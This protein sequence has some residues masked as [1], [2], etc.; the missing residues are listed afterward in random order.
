M[1][2][3][4]VIAKYQNSRLFRMKALCVL[5]AFVGLSVAIPS[6]FV[7]PPLENGGKNWAL[8]V[9][10]S[11]GWGNY[12]HQA[13]VC[14][15]YQILKSH[16]IPDEQIIVMM[17]D[18][19][20]NNKM[21][22]TPGKIINRP[23]GDDVYHGVLKDYT[24]LK[25]VAPDVFLKVLQG[26][27]EELA[28]IGSGKENLNS[29]TIEKQFKIVKRETNTSTVCQ[30]G[31]MKIDSMTVSEFQGSSQSNQIVYPIPDPNV[32]AVPSEDVD[33]H[34][35]MNLFKLA[36]TAEDRKYYSE[37]IAQ[38]SM[39]RGKVAPLIQKI[40]SIATNSN[41]RQ[42]ER[43]MK[44][45]M[46]LFRHECYKAAVEHLA[47]TCPQLEL[48]QQFGYAFKHLY[49]F[50][51]LCEE[52][53]PTET[54]LEAITKGCSLV[55]CA[56][57]RWLSNT[58]FGNPANW[59]A[60]RAPCGNDVA[61]IHDESAA[62]FLQVNTTVKQLLMPMNGEV[63]FGSDVV[64]G[65]TEQPDHSASCTPYSSNVEFNVTYP[66]DWFDS[67]NW[68]ET[69]SE[70]G[71]CK[72]IARL[73]SEKVPCMNDDVVYPSGNSFYVNLETGIDIKVNTFKITGKA[74]TTTS[75]QSFLSTDQGKGMFPL[76]NNGQRSSVTIQRRPCNDPTGC[77]CGN[78]KGEVLNRIC[79]IQRKRC[80]K[81]QCRTPLKPVGHCC[82]LCGGV[83]VMK[84]GSGF[85]FDTLVN[86][87][88]R[89]LIDG[90][91][92]YKDVQVIT[93][94]ISED[95][96][97]MILLD[98]DGVRA[99]QLTREIAKEVQNDINAGGFK[100]S[101][102]SV[103]V[104][105]SSGGG[106]TGPISGA[107]TA[108]SIP[109]GEIAGI[110]V[111]GAVVV[112]LLVVVAIF[113]YRR[114]QSFKKPN[115]RKPRVE[116][117]PSFGFRFGGPENVGPSQGFDN[118]MYGNN[119]LENEKPMDMEMMPSS[120]GLEQEEQPTFD[121]SRGFDNPLYDSPPLNVRCYEL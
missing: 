92:E 77:M 81:A 88:R 60:G 3:D 82:D 97:Q 72:T 89:N 105:V 26:K 7:F 33:L 20:A 111:G 1:T 76:P 46:G 99:S 44:A 67:N 80:T 64:L 28:G 48:R 32:G 65:F 107:Q 95:E 101:V 119:P 113:I 47:D 86:G 5:L 66:R 15:A 59:N 100:Y 8:L 121:S 54:I 16:G 23:E 18:D 112:G 49:A 42:V 68:C 70:T 19:I 83:A 57:K 12:R 40:V 13:D 79:V 104:D 62:V 10:G 37:K 52:S 106:S 31:D 108:E 21:N 2:G 93:S 43:I 53:V 56:Y 98:T 114:K 39:R 110:V 25:E 51:N 71:N 75:F 90:K 29:E 102:L 73:D 35:N 87:I 24:G 61:V 85:R 120:L 41:N 78:N 84:F 58:N 55:D 50:V 30:F 118:P 74:Y 11:N 45:R 6:D 9:A 94:K 91:S 109:N 34:I 63:V 38:E 14:H 96:I 117:P 17:V 27:K 36:S 4:H 22:P 115:F 116:V 69:D 103:R